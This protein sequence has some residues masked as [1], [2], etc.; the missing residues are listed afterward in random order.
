MTLCSYISVL[1]CFIDTQSR[2]PV[3]GTGLR[4]AVYPALSTRKPP[5][6]FT[7]TPSLC[8]TIHCDHGRSRSTRRSGSRSFVVC[9]E[10]GR[11]SVRLSRNCRSCSETNPKPSNGANHWRWSFCWVAFEKCIPWMRLCMPSLAINWL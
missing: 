4:C 1:K 8:W 5:R 7:S 6:C 10:T 3:S 9:I 2:F 11:L